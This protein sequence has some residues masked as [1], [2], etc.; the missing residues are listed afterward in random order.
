MK[1][2]R[3]KLIEKIRQL[4]KMTLENGC[5]PNEVEM[6]VRVA[7]EMMA[8]FDLSEADLEAGVGEFVKEA[9]PIFDDVT[10]QLIRIARA[11]ADLTDTKHWLDDDARVATK[12]T[13]FGQDA[14]VEIACY[15]RD[16]CERALRSGLAEHS[17]RTRLFRPAVARRR[18]LAFLTGMA[19]TLAKSIREI[20]WVR[21]REARA[22][23]KGIIL[24]KSAL[25]SEALKRQGLS[26]GRASSLGSF[27][28]DAG[29]AN[30]LED[31]GKVRFDAA[32]GSGVVKG[33][34]R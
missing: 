34:I 4:R 27:D 12:L 3:K 16:I 26:F 21:R 19:E 7:A 24:R 6:A 5:A 31:G 30:G 28:L 15:L 29:Y 23:G 18:N 9:A 2:D 13:F 25:V 14:D 8:K 32:V 22:S 1:D 20:D 11:I 33:L 17:K 10:R